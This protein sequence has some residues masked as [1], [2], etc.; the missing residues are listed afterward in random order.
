MEA[1]LATIDQ[2]EVVALITSMDS[3]LAE[4]RKA[5]E[6]LRIDEAG[7]EALDDSEVKRFA[8]E[9]NKAIKAANQRRIEFKKRWAEP[10][11]RIEELF[12]AELRDIND[13][14][15]LYKGEAD[16]R[17]AE[18]KA[19]LRAD[20]K[21]AYSEFLE[22]NGISNLE[23]NVPFE[24]IEDPQWL[25]KSYGA[26]KAE[27]ELIE[28]VTAIMTDWQAL[29][30][31]NLHYKE[32]AEAHFFETLSLREALNWDVEQFNKRQMLQDLK[33][34]I[35]QNQ[36]EYREPTYE[37]DPR[38]TEEVVY[39]DIEVEE[40]AVYVF[41]LEMTPSQL[42]SLMGF[43][44]LAEIHGNKAKSRFGTWQECHKVVKQHV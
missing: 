9:T 40:K 3:A 38:N 18:F 1:T 33:A 4:C 35:D 27:N 19:N 21:A 34:E 16:R 5:C 2:S 17:T 6:E 43:I 28:V 26:K 23:Q 20:L 29:G 37:P 12:N 39:P 7:L 32:D 8:A 25:N 31:A 22:A 42:D 10:V 30:N 11:K 13:L 41:T 24:R 14:H 36:V 44:R 15:D